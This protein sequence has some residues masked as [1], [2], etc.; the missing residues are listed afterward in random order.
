MSSTSTPVNE[1]SEDNMEIDTNNARKESTSSE[2][3]GTEHPTEACLQALYASIAHTNDQQ[4][5]VDVIHQVAP[6]PAVARRLCADRDLMQTI[7]DL[8]DAAHVRHTIEQT[9]AIA[10][11]DTDI[12]PSDWGVDGAGEFQLPNNTTQTP[13][14]V[15]NNLPTPSHTGLPTPTNFNTDP[16][17]HHNNYAFNSLPTT[18]FRPGETQRQGHGLNASTQLLNQPYYANSHDNA[19]HYPPLNQPMGSMPAFIPAASLSNIAQIP[20]PATYAAT[21]NP[22]TTNV[23]AIPQLKSSEQQR[24]NRTQIIRNVQ[25][26]QYRNATNIQSA[27][28]EQNNQQNQ[29]EALFESIR[30]DPNN[31]SRYY[32]TYKTQ[33]THDDIVQRGFR[34]GSQAIHGVDIGIPIVVP[35][36]PYWIDITSVTDL[37]KEYGEITKPK[38][39]ENAAHVVTG[40]LRMNI[41]LGDRPLPASITYCDVTMKIIREDDEK[42]CD[43]CHRS[44]HFQ[45][46]CR[47]KFNVQLQQRQQDAIGFLEREQNRR[48]K[49]EA[50]HAAA[51]HAHEAEKMQLMDERAAVLQHHNFREDNREVKIADER[52]AEA[53]RRR[54]AAMETEV[55]QIVSSDMKLQNVQK[56]IDDNA[57]KLTDPH[58]IKQREDWTA[59]DKQRNESQQPHGEELRPPYG[60]EQLQQQQ[61]NQQQQEL[62]Q[63]QQLQQQQKLQA[64]HQFQIEE[65]QTRITELHRELEN[66]TVHYKADALRTEQLQAEHRQLQAEQ[67]ELYSHQQ[68]DIT[69]NQQKY[70][71]LQRENKNMQTKLNAQPTTINDTSTNAKT[72]KAQNNKHKLELDIQKQQLETKEKQRKVLQRQLDEQKKK[73]AAQEDTILRLRQ[74]ADEKKTNPPRKHKLEE[75]PEPHQLTIDVNLGPGT[76]KKTPLTPTATL[77]NTTNL[78][79]DVTP[80]ITH[81]PAPT[82]TLSQTT[83]SLL[84]VNATELT[85]NTSIPVSHDIW[86]N[87]IFTEA[88]VKHTCYSIEQQ[89][90]A[91]NTT[92]YTFKFDTDAMTAHVGRK[93]DV[94]HKR[95][96]SLHISDMD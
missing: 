92:T 10:P 28:A 77:D 60:E 32:I 40:G 18:Y 20:P 14:N 75:E 19:Q 2:I 64:Q 48:N 24:K 59:R 84:N 29:P 95:L 33:Q 96:M 7:L 82:D 46:Q 30:A 94:I 57:Q 9:I 39:A 65:Q 8:N 69:D 43:F 17:P 67:Q 36:A 81:S 74:F 70:D 12:S 15:T 49:T 45:R 3:T 44:G 87:I 6:D 54:Q 78:N 58:L 16:P 68:Q 47:T 71:D 66:I 53:D 38:W 52:L 37:L 90:S 13:D 1:A 55:E 25:D 26:R 88:S 35:T 91:H 31:N 42:V 61:Q 34:L 86:K 11:A 51:S 83:A 73:M 85:I 89:L 63:Q 27:I 76:A 72:R 4:L 56:E 62:Q 80:S 79:T 23:T 41:K 5:I 22:T 50:K 21:L 93:W